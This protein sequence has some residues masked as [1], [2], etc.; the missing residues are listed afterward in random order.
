MRREPRVAGRHLA[1][2]HRGNLITRRV[3]SLLAY[4]PSKSHCH[5]IYCSNF[6]PVRRSLSRLRKN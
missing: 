4:E 5:C 3:T 1:S 2:F 6:T